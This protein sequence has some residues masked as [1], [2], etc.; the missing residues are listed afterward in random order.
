MKNVAESGWA[1]AYIGSREAWPLM[2]TVR[3]RRSQAIEAFMEI[4]DTT[5]FTWRK[6][7]DS[8]Q[9]KCVRVKLS[10]DEDSQ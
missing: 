2:Y 1:V 7:R 10:I 9:Y 6:F 4:R 8:G 5:K 3:F